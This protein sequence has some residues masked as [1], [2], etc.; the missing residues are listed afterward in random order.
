MEM[1]HRHR[2][3]TELK[4]GWI[5]HGELLN[6]QMVLFFGLCVLIVFMVYVEL[7]VESAVDDEIDM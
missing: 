1:A 7:N 5:F 2:W 4:D 6:N 3:F